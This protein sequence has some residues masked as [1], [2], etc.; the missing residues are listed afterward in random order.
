MTKATRPS[1]APPRV[2]RTRPP[3]NWRDSFLAALAR[4]SNVT[5]AART[6]RIAVS[7]AYKARRT[8][9]AFARAWRAALCEGYDNLEMDL[10]HRL[11]SGELE[12]GA[13]ARRRKYDNGAALRLLAA[14]R[15]SVTRQ[16][17]VRELADEESLV[18]AIKA[19]ID[20]MRAR[21]A[22]CAALLAG[23]ACAGERP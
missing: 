8:D 21:E 4:T 1:A 19:R 23:D 12:R 6:A 15:E 17:A 18:A 10:L 13:G 14:H 2:R 9:P 22:A 5:A 7:A 20:T 3:R 16:R 11:R